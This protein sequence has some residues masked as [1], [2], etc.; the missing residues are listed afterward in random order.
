MKT[1]SLL[2][3]TWNN[4]H[5]FLMLTSLHFHFQFINNFKPHFLFNTKE[6]YSN[7]WLTV[8]LISSSDIHK[9]REVSS[10]QVTIY[11]AFLQ[12]SPLTIFIMFR[13]GGGG[14]GGGG[15]NLET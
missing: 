3:G 14:G 8:N 15:L 5:K 13:G 12:R 6:T 7:A 4:K 2:F 11:P 9:P 1:D 10:C